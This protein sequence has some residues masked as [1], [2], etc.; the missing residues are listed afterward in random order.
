LL[1]ELPKQ[2]TNIQRNQFCKNIMN[3]IYNIKF[4]NKSAICFQ[5]MLSKTSIKIIDCV[6]VETWRGRVF[7]QRWWT[8][9]QGNRKCR[10]PEV[11]TTKQSKQKKWSGRRTQVYLNWN[12]FTTNSNLSSTPSPKSV[13]CV[14]DET[15]KQNV[16][17]DVKAVTETARSVIINLGVLLGE[18]DQLQG[19]HEMPNLNDI[20]FFGVHKYPKVQKR[21]LR[22]LWNVYGVRKYSF[23]AL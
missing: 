12:C 4:T 8:L 19:V 21:R 20:Y 22:Q 14:K 17:L 10:R 11:T 5:F 23:G 1:L 2:Y 15:A 7:K 13:S 3:Y 16:L 6:Q 18:S 9:L